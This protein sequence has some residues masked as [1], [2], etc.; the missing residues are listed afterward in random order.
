MMKLRWSPAWAVIVLSALVGIG[1][2]GSRWM[3]TRRPKPVHPRTAIAVLPFQNL[4]ADSVH[5]SF[6]AGL[7]DE[8]L[9]QLAK[10]A[11]LK[12]IGRTS[13]SEYQDTAKSLREIG[14]ELAVGSIVEG[15]VQ[16]DAGRL[17]VVVQLLDPTTREALWGERYDRPLDDAFALQSEIARHIVDA[18]GARLT[19]AEAD[20]ISAALAGNP[21]AYQFYLQGLDYW[22]RPGLLRSNFELAQRLFERSLALD[23]SFAPTH[24]ALALTHYALY[25]LRYDESPDRFARARRETDEAMRLAPNLP[26]ALL[27]AGLVRHVARRDYPGALNQ[28]RLGLQAAPNDA[29]L[30]GALGRAHRGLGNW[31]S[32]FVAF[33]RVRQLS[34]RETI[35]LQTLGDTYHLLHRY[36]EA[37]DAYRQELM[38]APDLVQPRLSLAWSYVLWRGELDTLRAVLGSLPQDSEI[39]HG[40]TTLL[41]NRLSLA[42]LERRGDSILSLLRTAPQLMGS[43]PQSVLG[44]SDWTIDAHLLRGDTAAA[45]AVNDSVGVVLDAQ[46]R[47]GS[48]DS[49]FHAARGHYFAQRGR[50]AEALREARW[51][52]QWET[53]NQDAYNNLAHV[54]VSVLMHAGEVDSAL[55]LVESLMLARPSL[56]TVH[57]LRLD[58]R[59]DPITQHPRFQALFTKYA[60]HRN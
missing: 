53:Q 32:M 44:R 6:A 60:D 45:Q 8:L 48:N 1:L 38:L 37:I 7:H 41:N 29:E 34:P 9:T 4:T 58:P 12:V 59:W 16:V 21:Q 30:W 47:A 57:Y 20:A 17:R 46:A 3:E 35:L 27:V 52:E 22:R 39:G 55:V 15:T 10:V 33:E 24:A 51:L 23:S 54:R 11:A 49:D 36:R 42:L 14:E 31:D 43:D 28:F 50:K 19:S 2:L 13:V 18:V 26:Q 5:G 40:G 25:D 56:V